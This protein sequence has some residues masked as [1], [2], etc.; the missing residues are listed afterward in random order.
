VLHVKTSPEQLVFDSVLTLARRSRILI[1]VAIVTIGLIGFA[2]AATDFCQ[3]TAQDAL[4]GCQDV[5]ESA[6]SVALGK[7]ANISDPTG[8]A[9]C[10][11]QAASDFHD[12]LQT[13]QGGFAS[14]QAACQKFGPARYDPV[15][16]PANF[17]RRVTNPFFPLP[18][19]Q[20]FV[21][22]G[23][24]MDGFLHN[25]VIVTHK[26]RLIMGVMCTEV[27]D[28]VYLDGKLAEDTLDWFAQDRQGNV[29]YF[30]ENTAEFDTEIGRPVTLAGTFTAGINNDKPGIIMEAN[31]VVGDFYRQEFALANAE[32]NAL[33]VSLNTTVTVPAGT[34]MHCLKTLETTPLEPDARENKYYA[35]G[36][37]NVLT[38][39][40]ET[41]E[42]I[43]LIKIHSNN[44]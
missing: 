35:S 42:R 6:Q 39:D 14:R 12:A 31:S 9:D 32:D 26:T 28:V 27:H 17:V 38:I 21:Y 10:R 40:L 23:Q 24:T 7:C 16:A 8:R 36:V 41:G 3:N 33:V 15:I 13:C 29:W 19:G 2:R 11:K 1:G 37:G 25:D 34:F 22:E 30:G 20:T 18:P 43:K 4:D 5:A 44:E